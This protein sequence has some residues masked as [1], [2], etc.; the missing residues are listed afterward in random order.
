MYQVV[1]TVLAWLNLAEG[2]HLELEAGEDLDLVERAAASDAADAARTVQQVWK[3]FLEVVAASQ[4]DLLKAVIRA[5]EW[6]IETGDSTA[7]ETEA[8]RRLREILPGK[9]PA[10]ISR[11]FTHLFAYVFRLLSSNGKR[12]LTPDF[13]RSSSILRPSVLK[14]SR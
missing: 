4:S 2:Q 9:S 12:E 11:A 14:T 13:F 7:L 8:S 3:S 10:V 5:F 1:A 6:A